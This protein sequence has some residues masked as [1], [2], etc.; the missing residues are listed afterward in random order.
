MDVECRASLWICNILS[1][2]CSCQVSDETGGRCSIFVS[3][4]IMPGAPGGADT[5]ALA[6]PMNQ[7][8]FRRAE[9]S[10][11]PGLPSGTPSPTF[12]PENVPVCIIKVQVVSWSTTR[13]LV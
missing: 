4:I 8:T 12:S 10:A 13:V 5:G 9:M 2:A 1:T 3:G 7:N 11:Q 6:E